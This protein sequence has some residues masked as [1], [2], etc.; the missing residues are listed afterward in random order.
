MTNDTS[1]S[2]ALREFAD[3]QIVCIHDRTTTRM[4]G[5]KIDLDVR[6]ATLAEL[7]PRDVGRWKAEQFADQQIPTLAEVP[8]KEDVAEDMDPS[9][10]RPKRTVP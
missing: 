1:I 10:C 9:P 8:A 3:G 7:R 5:G 4:P 2:E 6:R